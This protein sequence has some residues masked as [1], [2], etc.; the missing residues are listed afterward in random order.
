MYEMP[1]GSY[2]PRQNY[3][4]ERSNLKFWFLWDLLGLSLSFGGQE[5]FR[6]DRE[7]YRTIWDPFQVQFHNFINLK[8][9]RTMSGLSNSWFLGLGSG[10][11]SISNIL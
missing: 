9:L 1:A 7:P 8:I 3:L 11:L 4:D 10:S 6:N 5:G 2:S